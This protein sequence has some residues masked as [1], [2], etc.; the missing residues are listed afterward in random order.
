MLYSDSYISEGCRIVL[1][2]RE[3]CRVIMLAV[4]ETGV[5]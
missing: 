5:V 3:G 4:L 2:Y 1:L